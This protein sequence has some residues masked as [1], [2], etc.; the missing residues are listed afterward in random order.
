[1]HPRATEL[2]D[3]LE[4]TPHPEGGY[5]KES[6]RSP[7]Q[8]ASPQHGKQRCAVTDIYFLLLAGQVSRIHKVLHDELW[9]FYEGAALELIEI[10]THQQATTMILGN[11]N[12]PPK[13]QHC[14][15][16]NHWQAARSTGDYTLVGCT[17]APGFDFADFSF[18]KNTAEQALIIQNNPELLPFI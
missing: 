10:N 17:V 5:Y 4:L 1:M 3:T 16:A 12:L 14:I 18:L 8:L 9:H 13:Y 2:I 7:I 6:Y 11:S 15:H